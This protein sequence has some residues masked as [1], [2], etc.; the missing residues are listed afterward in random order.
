MMSLVQMQSVEN[1]IILNQIFVTYDIHASDT[2][3]LSIIGTEY[4]DLF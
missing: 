2:V 4:L 3:A 1:S